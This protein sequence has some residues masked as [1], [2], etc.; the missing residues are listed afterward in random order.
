MQKQYNPLLDA[1]PETAEVNGRTYQIATDYRIALA[2]I[3]LQESDDMTDQ[4]KAVIALSMF[5]GPQVQ[6]EDMECLAEHLRWYLRRGKEDEAQESSADPVFDIQADAGRIFAAF[7]QIYRI[8]LRKVRMHW[9]IF[10]ELLDALPQGTH[11]ADVIEI[12]QRPFRQGMSAAEKNSLARMKDHF[13]IG[14]YRSPAE[15]LFASLLEAAR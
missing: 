2:Y 10:L 7:L 13:R 8:N 4:E 1:P 15:G 14:N 9:W 11:L 12:R 6:I 5:Y 3:R